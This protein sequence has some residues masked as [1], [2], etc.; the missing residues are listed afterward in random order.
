[1]NNWKEKLLELK[2]C[3]VCAEPLGA[4]GVCVDCE[5][6]ADGHL[7]DTSKHRTSNIWVR[8][9]SG[10]YLSMAEAVRN[11]EDINSSFTKMNS[12]F[13]PRPMIEKGKEDC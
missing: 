1:M 6:E 3:E 10:V 13:P 11:G 8:V 4:D 12:W 5:D 2:F 7:V 9:D